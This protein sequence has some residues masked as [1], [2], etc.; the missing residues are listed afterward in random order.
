M[1][2]NAPELPAERFGSLADRDRGIVTS[3]RA[4]AQDGSTLLAVVAVQGRV[5]VPQF[6]SS[7]DSGLSWRQGALSTAAAES[8]RIGEEITEV[9][10]VA[11]SGGARRWLALGRKDDERIAWTSADTRTWERAVLS[12]VDARRASVNAVVGTPEGFVMV[13]SVRDE[14]DTSRPS[15]W[16]SS[17]GIAWQQVDVPG[18]GH[19]SD[20]AVRG[21]TL[22]AAGAHRRD[23]RDAQGRL[24]SPI[25]VTS[26]DAG[27]TWAASVVAEPE[28]S[29]NFSTVLDQVVVTPAG[30]V[31]AGEFYEAGPSRYAGWTARSGDGITWQTDPVV[32]N[33]LDRAD[34]VGL[35][36]TAT[37]VFLVQQLHRS[38]RHDQLEVL[39]QDPEGRW[40]PLTGLPR[41]EA[42]VSLVAA[43]GVG[44]ALVLSASWSD[45]RDHG[46][47]WRMTAAD[48]AWMQLQIDAP[49]TMGSRVSPSHLLIRGDALS[50]WGTAQGATVEW[51]PSIGAAPATPGAVDVAEPR[52]VRDQAGEG[53]GGVRSGGGGLLVFGSRDDEPQVL[54]SSDGMQWAEAGPGTFNPVQTYHYAQVSDAVWAGD[55][56]IVVG[57]RSSNGSA[58]RS[59]LVFTS[60]GSGWRAG[61]HRQVFARGDAFDTDDTATDLQGL[62]NMGRSMMAVAVAPAGVLAVGRTTVV[63]GT[64]PAMWRS[65]DKLSWSLEPLPLDGF[66]EALAH[67]I[68]V[69][70]ERV[71]IVGHG[72]VDGSLDWV[73]LT[74]ASGDGG[75]TFTPAP[76]RLGDQGRHGGLATSSSPHGF[77]VAVTA[78]DR[79]ASPT[80]WR[81]VDGVAWQSQPLTL[82]PPAEGRESSVTDIAVVGDALVVLGWVTNRL[83]SVPVLVQVPLA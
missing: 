47:I 16:R 82:T 39:R 54:T 53:F 15:A 69:Q 17:D 7:D 13:G 45:T 50:V 43:V 11:G 33:L 29:A 81:S 24:T 49:P 55:R 10:A 59:A 2:P 64:R 27:A 19:L 63:E 76:G 4:F 70:G 18:E 25:L 79:S 52:L 37:D 5:T 78:H 32:P 12:G 68:E 83:D 26:T 31:V 22:V 73:P 57:E 51:Q 71:L 6:W 65:L 28:A 1:P 36:A 48:E 9:A 44:E 40:R 38:G 41:P 20:V 34:V 30:F 67:D 58:R 8:T 61:T 14:A 60:E 23:A 66:V 77:Q 42:P 74:W 80:L 46:A 72:R 35:A 3:A 62:E 21:A 75:A 56:W